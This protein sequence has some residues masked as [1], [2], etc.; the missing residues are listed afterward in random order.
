LHKIVQSICNK[1]G[2]EIWRGKGKVK[3]KQDINRNMI[4]CIYGTT[5]MVGT[6]ALTGRGEKKDEQSVAV[7]A[8]LCRVAIQ[9]EVSY[10][11]SVLRT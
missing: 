2:I 1:D 8:G 5:A 6:L 3:R 10:F 11:H 7:T 9:Y 4:I